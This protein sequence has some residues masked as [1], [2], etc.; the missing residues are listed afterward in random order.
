KPPGVVRNMFVE[1]VRAEY[2]SKCV[3]K[4]EWDRDMEIEEFTK[5]SKNNMCKIRVCEVDL[6]DSPFVS[7]T[8]SILYYT[9][10]CT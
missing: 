9:V 6:S 10:E 1:S 3:Q 4:T 2:M 7:L 8:R 5:V